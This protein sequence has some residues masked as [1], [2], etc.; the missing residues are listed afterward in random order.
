MVLVPLVAAPSLMLA[1]SAAERRFGPAVAGATAALPVALS[2]VILAV[3]A[4]LG[5]DAGATLATAAAA[6]VVA[7]VVFA[8]TFAA[9]VSRNGGPLGL[10]AGV[11]AFALVS[12]LVGP[13]PP[14]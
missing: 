11:T 2:I 1:V 14:A 6:H 12:L 5:R 10:L 3:G 13:L 8:L 4:E 9:V 7:Q